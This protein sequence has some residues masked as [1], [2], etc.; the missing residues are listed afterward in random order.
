METAWSMQQYTPRSSRPSH[1]VLLLRD[2]RQ[3][4]RLGFVQ[5]HLGLCRWPMQQASSEDLGTLRPA[6]RVHFTASAVKIGDSKLSICTQPRGQRVLWLQYAGKSDY[7]KQ[8]KSLTPSQSTMVPVCHSGSEPGGVCSTRM[9]F[10]MRSAPAW[11]AL[12]GRLRLP[13]LARPL[14]RFTPLPREP[15]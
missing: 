5:S 2:S 4:A 13:T 15:C 10:P 7:G 8:H 1:A 3:H 12:A 9:R 11:A 6:L 14:P